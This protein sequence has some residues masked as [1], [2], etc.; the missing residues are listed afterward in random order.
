MAQIMERVE[1]WHAVAMLGH[2]GFDPFGARDGHGPFPAEGPRSVVGADK[3]EADAPGLGRPGGEELLER[4]EHD[5]ERGRHVGPAAPRVD[6]VKMAVAKWHE[7]GG[8]L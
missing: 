7:R 2:E 3:V 5:R 1:I 6:V 8:G 4:A